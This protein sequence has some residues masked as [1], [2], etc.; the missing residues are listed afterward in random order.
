MLDKRL[1]DATDVDD[2]LA[3]LEA[4]MADEQA[5]AMPTVPT[6]RILAFLFACELATSHRC[7]ETLS[8]MQN[9]A[10]V[11]PTTTTVDEVGA[12]ETNAAHESPTAPTHTVPEGDSE[13]AQQDTLVPA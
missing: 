5:A 13:V 9:V 2:E 1:G 4:E 12:S 10:E 6:V 8:V 7:Q 11:Q 3:A